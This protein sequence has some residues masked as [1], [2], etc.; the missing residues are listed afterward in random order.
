[1][2]EQGMNVK[3]GYRERPDKTNTDLALPPIPTVFCPA[4]AGDMRLEGCR[5]IRSEL[6]YKN[7]EL[8]KGGVEYERET[9]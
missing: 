7:C 4:I 6:A 1:M 9:V 3:C 8:C 2:G 5:S